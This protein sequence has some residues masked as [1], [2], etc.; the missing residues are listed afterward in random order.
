MRILTVPPYSKWMDRP[1]VCINTAHSSY[2][3]VMMNF[4]QAF[5]EGPQI[6]PYCITVS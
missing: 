1:L 5:K 2:E 4:S 6:H 3:V